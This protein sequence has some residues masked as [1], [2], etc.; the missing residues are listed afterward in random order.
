MNAD[1]SIQLVLCLSYNIK[2]INFAPM[3]ETEILRAIQSLSRGSVR[4]FRNNVGFDATN[5]VRYGLMPGSSDLIG[6]KTIEI[7]KHHV[8]KKIAVFTAIEVKKK[9]GRATPGQRQFIEVVD[10]SGGLAGICYSI[11]EAIDLLSD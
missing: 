7:T 5:K 6:W 2:I 8:G 4:L 3:T 1:K 9:G 10:Q 11:E